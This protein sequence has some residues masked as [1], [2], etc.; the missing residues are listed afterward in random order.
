MFEPVH[1]GYLL[2]YQEPS[3]LFPRPGGFL[4]SSRGIT[5]G[6]A[7]EDG[8]AV[9][10]LSREGWESVDGFPDV[11]FQACGS[12]ALP[13]VLKFGVLRVAVAG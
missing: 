4:L 9:E 11:I 7:E 5:A 3:A 13:G 12:E 8:D 6:G 10:L 2:K 1:C